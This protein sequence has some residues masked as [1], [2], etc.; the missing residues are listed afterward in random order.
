[1]NETTSPIKTEDRRAYLLVVSPPY[2]DREQFRDC[3]LAGYDAAIAHPSRR[4]LVDHTA[5][6]HR[7]PVSEIYDLGLTLMGLQGVASLRIALVSNPESIYPDR[8]FETVAK[9]RGMGVQV[10][11]DDFDAAVSWLDS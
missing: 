9:N 10:F 11:V 3:I 7:V 8:F 4:V 6:R 1:M 2:R 5:T